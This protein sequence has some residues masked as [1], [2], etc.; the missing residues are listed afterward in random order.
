[1]NSEYLG[2][3][4]VGSF[5]SKY[6]KYYP[7]VAHIRLGYSDLTKLLSNV[8]QPNFET[9]IFSAKQIIYILVPL[10]NIG[11]PILQYYQIQDSVLD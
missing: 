1:M 4:S 7:P 10:H 8:K 5:R 11:N 6:V 2:H 3:H 9:D